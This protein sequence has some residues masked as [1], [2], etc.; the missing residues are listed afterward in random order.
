M[1]IPA[2][3]NQ[4]CSERSSIRRVHQGNRERAHFKVNKTPFASHSLHYDYDWKG[5][6]LALHGDLIRCH[7]RQTCLNFFLPTHLARGPFMT[8]FLLPLGGVYY[9]FMSCILNWWRSVPYVL[10]MPPRVIR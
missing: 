8:I 5:I 4:S 2:P 9:V 7:R 1:K 6:D 3:D 10:S